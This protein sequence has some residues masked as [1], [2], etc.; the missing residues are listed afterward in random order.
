MRPGEAEKM[1][2][3]IPHPTES[4][5]TP[6]TARKSYAMDVAEKSQT[7]YTKAAVRSRRSYKVSECLL[8]I[9]A[10]GIPVTAVVDRK[11]ALVPAV[12]GAIVVVLSSLRGVFHWQENYLRFS[13][14]REALEAERR[15]YLTSSA[16]YDDDSTKDQNLA[17]VV[18]RIEQEEM[19]T[20]LRIA[21]ERP[22]LDKGLPRR[23]AVPLSEKAA[24]A[25]V[26][27]SNPPHSD[28]PT[29]TVTM[30]RRSGP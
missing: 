22:T 18:T 29:H 10:A 5:P 25:Q 24:P 28:S 6:N 7:W 13:R 1:G 12:L 4:A 23:R 3:A 14:A 2:D 9:I 27:L 15:S 16:P 30:T 11:D 21:A 8:I 17:A 26:S 19:G 20:W